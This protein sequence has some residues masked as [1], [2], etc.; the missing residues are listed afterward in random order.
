MLTKQLIQLIIPIRVED[1]EIHAKPTVK[2]LR[3][4]SR[5]VMIY[6]EQIQSHQS[7]RFSL[8]GYEPTAVFSD[9]CSC[10]L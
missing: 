9:D 1:F 7:S 10:I 2:Y 8:L 3:A 4:G 5:R 6:F